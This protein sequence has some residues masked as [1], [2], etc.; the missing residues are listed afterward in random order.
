ML[1][2]TANELEAF[3]NAPCKVVENMHLFILADGL[4]GTVFEDTPE[5]KVGVGGGG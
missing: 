5:E 2:K 4:K 1:Q 3:L